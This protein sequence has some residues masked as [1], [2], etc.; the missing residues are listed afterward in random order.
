MKAFILFIIIGLIKSVA[1]TIRVPQ[2]F[3]TSIFAQYK[4]NTFIDPEVSMYF[5]HLLPWWLYPFYIHFSDLWHMLNSAIIS[6]YIISAFTFHYYPIFEAYNMG[7]AMH[8]LALFTCYGIG[9]ETGL[10]IIIK[11]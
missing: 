4:G 8:F 7:Y 5:Q 9:M 10:K 11:K 2:R 1:D 6:L 3:N